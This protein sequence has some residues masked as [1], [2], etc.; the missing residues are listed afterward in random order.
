VIVND[1][2][3]DPR[4]YS[5][6]SEHLRFRVKSLIGVPMMIKDRVI[7]VLEAVNNAEEFLMNGT[8]RFFL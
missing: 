8:K 7:G 1:A 6:V 4:H 3:G 5:L 2:D